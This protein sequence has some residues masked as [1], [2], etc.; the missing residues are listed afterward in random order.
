MGPPLA[1]EPHLY[2][3]CRQ[4]D[5]G[6]AMK[7]TVH[8]SCVHTLSIHCMYHRAQYGTHWECS[9]AVLCDIRY[10]VIVLVQQENTEKVEYFS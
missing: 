2:H 9:I 3:K 8:I 1:V 5:Q 6:L 10:P 4:C 7:P